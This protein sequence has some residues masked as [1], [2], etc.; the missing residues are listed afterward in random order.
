M[1]G[2]S[3]RSSLGKLVSQETVPDNIVTR[4]MKIWNACF[5][6][7]NYPGFAVFLEKNMKNNYGI[8]NFTKRTV[9]I[10][11][12]LHETLGSEAMDAT[13]AHELIHVYLWYIDS[14]NP[15][16]HDEIFMD[17]AV[18]LGKDDSLSKSAH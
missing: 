15:W 11:T 13:I 5:P 7:T 16:D 14:P 3:T 12:Y 6:N 2:R 10:S 18:A 17:L 9:K 8:T 4:T 1:S